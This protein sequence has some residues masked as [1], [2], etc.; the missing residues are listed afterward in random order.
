MAAST[1]APTA[2]AIP[3]SDMMLTLRP[4]IL[5]GMNAIKIDT[6]IVITGII[7]LGKCQ[8]KIKITSAT[9][10]IASSSVVFSVL[11]ERLMR[12]ERSY[13]GTSSRPAGI[14]PLTSLMRA[15]TRSMTSLTCSP[16]CAIT[17]PLTV[18][19]FPLKSA[20]PRRISGPN[21]TSATSPIRTRRSFSI[22]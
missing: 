21:S 4:S 7:E 10:I 12:S 20:T 5:N 19:P 14:E 8:R 18:S 16:C 3:P 11:I 13:T 17:M 1:I 22:P 15:F 9:T 6:G 2:I